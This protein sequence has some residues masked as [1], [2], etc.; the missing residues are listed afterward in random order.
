MKKS[1]LVAPV[2]SRIP[3]LIVSVAVACLGLSPVMAQAESRLTMGGT[4]STSAFYSYQVAVVSDWNNALKGK[5]RMTIQELGGAAASTEALLRGEVD[6]GISVTSSD[7]NAVRGEGSFKKPS[8]TLRTL[9]FFAPLPLNWAVAADSGIESI[10]AIG[11]KPFSPGGRGTAT[12]GQTEAV[13]KAIGL[14]LQLSRGGASDALEAYQNRRI[15]GFIKAGLHPDGYLQQAHASRPVRLLQLSEEQ[16]NKV[17]AAYPY[18]SVG[19]V[20]N[21]SHY[22]NQPATSMT[23]QTAIGINTSTN[24]SADVAYAI[25]KRAFSAEGIAAAAS[26][27]A[28]AAQSNAIEL[29][30]A[31]AVAPLHAGVVRYLKE[32]KIEV[33]KHL[34]P[35][36]YKD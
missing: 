22:G 1:T 11:D 16:A 24:L 28:P 34:I 35:P 13:L 31:A 23:V 21:G 14:N 30:L 9:Y 33:P 2:T 15:I 12:E 18:F 5:M 25:V 29:T 7:F 17:V 6:M 8:N 3:A 19:K 20:Q 10:A 4:H 26:G 36:E 27:Y 32:Q